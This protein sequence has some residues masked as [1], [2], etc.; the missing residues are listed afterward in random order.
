MDERTIYCR[1]PHTGAPW[2]LDTQPKPIAEAKRRRQP[3]NIQRE[4]RETDIDDSTDSN[5]A[6]QLHQ[7]EDADQG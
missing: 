7:H 2:V 3:V 5:A 1:D 4:P 6:P